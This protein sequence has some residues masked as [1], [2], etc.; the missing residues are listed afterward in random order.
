MIN[1][2]LVF[3]ILFYITASAITLLSLVSLNI[4]RTESIAGVT[5][6]MDYLFHFA[7]YFSMALFLGRWKCKEKLDK[8]LFIMILIFGI[9]SS[10]IFEFI[11]LAI[12]NRVFNPL[13]VFFNFIGFCIGV[14]IAK[15]IWRNAFKKKY[16]NV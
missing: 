1:N 4:N 15:E 9:V 5:F 16:H 7:A 6:R 11:Q 2:R 10:S 14:I 3:K 12:P 13:D 8:K